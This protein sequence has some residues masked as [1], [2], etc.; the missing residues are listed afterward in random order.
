MPST[1]DDKF[2]L[3]A[4]TGSLSVTRSL[5]REVQKSYDLTVFV[6]DQEQPMQ[7][8]MATVQITVEDENDYTP[9]FPTPQ[10]AL[11]IPE[12]MAQA[13]F[14]TVVAQDMDSGE[15]GQIIYQITGTVC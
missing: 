6:E 10:V 4:A 8:D 12:N 13:G 14:Y 11:R 3:D 15:N 1:G 9:V 2:S 5:D 7:H